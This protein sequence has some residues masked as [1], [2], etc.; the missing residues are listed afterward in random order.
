MHVIQLKGSVTLGDSA[1][2]QLDT[3]SCA[4]KI[5]DWGNEIKLKL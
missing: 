1:L 2:V 3:L 4:V 5:D